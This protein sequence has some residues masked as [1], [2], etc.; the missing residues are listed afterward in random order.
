[1][2][3]NGQKTQALFLTAMDA[4]MTM[5]R[6]VG[7]FEGSGFNIERPPLNA[8]TSG[9]DRIISGINQA[10]ELKKFILD[11]TAVDWWYSHYLMGDVPKVITE[12]REIIVDTPEKLWELMRD[13]GEV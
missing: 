2:K 9:M 8:L 12:D 5:N 7:K 3:N 10:L 6:A 11:E 1:M 4:V 13:N